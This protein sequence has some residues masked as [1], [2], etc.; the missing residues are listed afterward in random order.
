MSLVKI[1]TFSLLLQ[2]SLFQYIIIQQ[3]QDFAWRHQIKSGWLLNA[4]ENYS[5]W[6]YIEII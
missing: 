5:S 6:I 1:C 2:Q 4:D 3:S